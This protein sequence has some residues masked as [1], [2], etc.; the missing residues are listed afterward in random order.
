MMIL[1]ASL[2]GTVAHT[3]EFPQNS[4]QIILRDGQVE[5]RLLVDIDAWQSTLSDPTAWLTGET[6]LLLTQEDL[7]S[8]A[9]TDKLAQYLAGAIELTLEQEALVFKSESYQAYATGHKD[10]AEQGLVEFRLSARHAFADPKGLSVQFPASLASVLVSVVQP[11]YGLTK[12]GE[13][14]IFS[15]Q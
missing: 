4:A 13:T 10:E 5:V 1:L 9:L 2:I 8:D 14:K 12:A 11:Q 15:L 7:S 6:D 3:H